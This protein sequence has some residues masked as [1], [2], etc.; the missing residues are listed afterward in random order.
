MG[1][2]KKLIFL[3][4]LM[5]KFKWTFWP[6]RYLLVTCSLWK[7]TKRERWWCHWHGCHPWSLHPRGLQDSA[8]DTICANKGRTQQGS[9]HVL[10]GSFGKSVMQGQVPPSSETGIHLQDCPYHPPHPVLARVS[11]C[12]SCWRFH[13]L[14]ALKLSIHLLYQT[15]I[16]DGRK[17][18]CFS[19]SPP[20]LAQYLVSEKHSR[21]VW[22]KSEAINRLINGNDFCCTCF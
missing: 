20:F 12:W 8:S 5:D 13:I 19:L 7:L 2:A 14:C 16:F 15:C 9:H 4:H 3:E 18:V 10:C 1:L 11:P 21:S 22:W 6:S 17:Q